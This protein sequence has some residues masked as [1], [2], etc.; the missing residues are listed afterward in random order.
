MPK[1][2]VVF[3][4]GTAKDG[5]HGGNTN[6]YKLFN[7]VEDRTEKQIAFYDRGLGTSW[8]RKFSGKFFGRGIS[9]N[10]L[11]CYEFIFDNY[12]SGDQVF[13]FGFSR[14]ATTVRSLSSFIDLF[15]ILPKSRPEL[16]K[17]AYE[18]YA[19]R[20][21]RTQKDR[22]DEFIGRNHTMR[23]PIKFLGVWDTVSALGI[24]IKAIDVVVD[25][26]SIFRHSFHNLRLSDNVENGRHALALDDERLTFHP[27]LWDKKLNE[28]QSVK[29]V[30]F[31]GMHSDVGGGYKK[32]ETDLSDVPLTWMLAEAKEQGLLIYDNHKVEINPDPDGMIHNST[33][34][35]PGVIYRRKQRTWESS[36]HQ[37]PTVHQSVLL[38]TKN[39]KNEM[40]PHYS[41]WILEQE[42]DVEPW[43]QESRV[44]PWL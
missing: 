43:P 10:I 32:E 14:G 18:I 13:L 24:P 7:M 12:Q 3:S 6:V 17:E 40:E 4:D 27:T 37:K 34:G 35:F 9:N 1:N 39:K 19:T 16:I 21:V 25:R 31:C 30:W 8:R 44:S 36:T 23:C 28:G 26:L 33:K 41:P 2:I 11:E 22:A 15:G 29:Q 5:G 20:N 42:H 38:R